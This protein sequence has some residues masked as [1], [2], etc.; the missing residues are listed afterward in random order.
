MK[1]A[2]FGAG[3]LA[4]M[5]IQSDKEKKH[6]F[7]VIDPSD[8]PPA[9]NYAQHIQS[10]YNDKNT[11]AKVSKHCDIATID[12]ENVCVESM[13]EIEKY[14]PVRPCPNALEI[15]QDRLKEKN[16]F[17]NLDIKTTNFSEVNSLDDLTQQIQQNKSYILKSRR[18][19]YDGK[20]QYRIK[21]NTE[22]MTDLI[23]QEC[24]LEEVVNFDAEVSLI[25][26]K[27][28]DE[29]VMY[30]PLIENTHK[31]GI[32]SVSRFPSKYTH[33]QSDAELIGAKLLESM[34]Y[35][36]VLVIEFF[37][38]ADQLLA[39]EMAPRVHNSGHWTID[40]CITSQ[41][42]QLVRVVCGLPLGSTQRHSNALMQNLI[43]EDAERWHEVT[44]NNEYKL[45]LYGKKTVRSGRKMGHVTRLLPLAPDWQN[46]DIDLA[47][48]IMR[49]R[50]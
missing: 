49:P 44:A 34:K 43:G 24:I 29:S 33:L 25:C 6:E 9:S 47:M 16:L 31:N 8:N 32:L 38:K 1:I 22:I 12:F 14:I 26:V 17:K 27:S 30:F 13:R 19:G 36:G 45:H 11:L 23:S 46:Q 48:S 28:V 35:V 10:E 40:A 7:L 21:P 50:T 42:E 3:Q 2:I 15:C 37:V 5:M 20:N 41:F 39:N 18:F 4:M